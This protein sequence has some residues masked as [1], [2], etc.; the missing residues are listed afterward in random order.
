MRSLVQD[1]LTETYRS[2]TANWSVCETSGV[3]SIMSE[4]EI[5]IAN[6]F[7]ARGIVEEPIDEIEMI[8]T[9]EATNLEE[10]E[11]NPVEKQLLPQ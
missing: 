1:L 6:R 7:S 2:A 10:P 9:T 3:E 5:P 4:N 11:I 8:I